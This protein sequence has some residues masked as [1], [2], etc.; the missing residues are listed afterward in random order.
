M[1]LNLPILDALSQ[2]KNVL[3]D[4]MGGGFDLFCG[5][6][7]YFELQRCGLTPH[8]ASFSWFFACHPGWLACGLAKKI[9]GLTFSSCI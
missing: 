2:C 1:R 3:I 6:P 7:M 5:L 8:L 9:S 4:G